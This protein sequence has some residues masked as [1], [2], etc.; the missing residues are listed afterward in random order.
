VEG[1]WG[2]GGG[3]AVREATSQRC[4]VTLSAPN[5]VPV[6]TW[7]LRVDLRH[8]AEFQGHFLDSEASE[9]SSAP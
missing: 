7:G 1:S 8:V 4:C 9:F 3:S 6:V 2:V 5:S